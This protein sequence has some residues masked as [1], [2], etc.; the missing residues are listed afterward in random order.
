MA[1]AVDELDEQFSLRVRQFL[2]AW[3]IGAE[4]VV[5]HALDMLVLR[6][7]VGQR[8]QILSRFNEHLSGL[9][10]DGQHLLHVV[11]QSL[12]RLRLFL[13]LERQLRVHVHVVHL[14]I[15]D[16][17]A[18]MQCF[19]HLHGRHEGR[20]VHLCEHLLGSQLLFLLPHGRGSSHH[21]QYR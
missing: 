9:L 17:V 5:L 10:G 16:A 11:H 4:D 7:F 2:H 20:R 18:F 19:P 14:H 12:V 13:V 3:L 1:L 15:L 6:L 8:L 21:R